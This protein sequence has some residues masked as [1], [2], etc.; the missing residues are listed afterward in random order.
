MYAIEA[1]LSIGRT[2]A[3]GM[4]TGGLAPNIHQQWFMDDLHE[5][6]KILF[7][8]KCNNKNNCTYWLPNPDHAGKEYITLGYFRPDVAKSNTQTLCGKGK[9]SAA[10][11]AQVCPPKGITG[12]APA[13]AVSPTTD[14]ATPAPATPEAATPTAAQAKAAAQAPSKYISQ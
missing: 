7:R 1:P 9:L 3:A 2:L 11:E 12:A 14:I 5:G 4:L 10:V 6:D 13:P 8:F